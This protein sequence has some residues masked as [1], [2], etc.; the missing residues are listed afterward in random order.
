[1]MRKQIS[2]DTSRGRP[3]EFDE[4]VVIERAMGVFWSRGYHGTSLPDLLEATRLSRGSLYAAFGDKHALFLR[5]LGRYV[6][7]AM[8]RLD[9]ELDPRRGA[10]EGVRACVDGYIDRTSGSAGRRGCLLVASAME[11]AAHDPEVAKHIR[12][13]FRGFET[14]VSGALARAKSDGHLREDLDPAILARLLLCQVEGMRV[15]GKVG[16]DKSAQATV[17]FLIDSFVK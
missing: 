4:D 1:M 13:F 14:R 12:R 16:Q 15:V 3:R 9:V 7:D 17:R 8:K 5:A 2:P 11:L 10:L 6:D